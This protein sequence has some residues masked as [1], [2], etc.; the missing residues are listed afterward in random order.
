MTKYF[1]VAMMLAVAVPIAIA[2]FSLADVH[3]MLSLKKLATAFEKHGEEKITMIGSPLPRLFGYAIEKRVPSLDEEILT[4]KGVDLNQFYTEESGEDFYFFDEDWVYT[5]YF[6]KNSYGISQIDVK[7]PKRA[8]VISCETMMA[9]NRA[10]NVF[11]DQELSQYSAFPFAR[12]KQCDDSGHSF[13]TLYKKDETIYPEGEL[14]F[15]AN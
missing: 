14:L 1:I 2:S 8:N 6:E 9:A 10:F 4:V 5:L 13:S 3:H 7:S 12:L 15:F 11:F